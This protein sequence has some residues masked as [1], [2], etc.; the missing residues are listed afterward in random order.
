MR[1][2]GRSPS[3]AEHVALSSREVDAPGAKVDATTSPDRCRLVEP[4]L[5]PPL[6]LQL[7]PPLRPLNAPP[8]PVSIHTNPCTHRPP[9]PEYRTSSPPVTHPVD[10]P[11]NLE[12]RFGSR[13]LSQFE[14]ARQRERLRFAEQAAK[15]VE[16]MRREAALRRGRRTSG[17]VGVAPPLLPCD[18]SISWDGTHSWDAVRS[19]GNDRM[20]RDNP[21]AAQQRLAFSQIVRESHPALLSAHQL[22]EHQHGGAA[23]N[24]N[25]Y[26]GLAA[27][28]GGTGSGG[29]GSARICRHSSLL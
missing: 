19:A 5:P 27:G 2:S 18:P 14:T 13:K 20:R 1:I 23:A 11:Q 3:I 28:S 24:G 6:Q 17:P 4:P 9:E 22:Q 16:T 29:G 12:R 15:R 8:E 25:G 21:E 10:G 7:P 26:G